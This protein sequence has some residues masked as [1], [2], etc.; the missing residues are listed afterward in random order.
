MVNPQ[1]QPT[2]R[3]RLSSPSREHAPRLQPVSKPFPR[4]PAPVASL[5]GR[6]EASQAI[7]QLVVRPEIRLVTMTGAG[8]I[9]KTCLAL[10]CA[11][12]VLPLF[13]D[14]ACFVPLASVS[15]PDFVLPELIHTLGINKH[16]HLSSLDSLTVF[17]REKHLLLVLDN[18]EH[19]TDAAPLLLD[20][21][22]ACANLTLLVTSRTVLHL[23]GEHVFPVP[24]LVLPD[25]AAANAHTLMTNP[26]VALFVARAQARQPDF[27]V[28]DHNAS[29]LISLCRRLD[30]LPLALELAAARVN[31]LSPQQLLSRLAHRLDLLSQPGH[32]VPKRH[33]TMRATIQWSYD[34]LTAREQEL[35]C[36]LSVFAED[37]SFSI[38]EAWYAQ[39]GANPAWLLEGLSS[40]LDKNLLFQRS[41]GEAEPLFSQLETI[42]AFGQ[43]QLEALGQRENVRAAHAACYAALIPPPSPAQLG[44]AEGTW[45]AFLKQTYPNLLVALHFFKEQQELAQALHLA[46]GM[47]GIWSVNGY[48]SEGIEELEHLLALCH[49]QKECVPS[50]L[51]SVAATLAGRIAWYNTVLVLTRRWYQAALLPDQSVENNPFLILAI[52]GLALIESEQ[53]NYAEYDALYHTW[54]PRLRAGKNPELLARLLSVSPLIWLRRGLLEQAEADARECLALLAVQHEPSWASAVVLHASG[55]IAFVREEWATA[56]ALGQE[57]V[58]MFRQLGM[59]SF[60]LEALCTFAS[61]TAA[62]GNAERAHS[63][64]EEAL[65][66]S[67][68][69]DDPREKSRACCGLGY[70]ALQRAD[71]V[72][73]RRWFEDSLTILLPVK[74]LATR[75][76]HLL[77][78][79]LEGLACITSAQQHFPQTVWLLGAAESVRHWDQYDDPLGKARLW[80]ERACSAARDA[81][82]ESV[83]FAAFAQGQKLTPAQAFVLQKTEKKIPQQLSLPVPST[84]NQRGKKPD[85]PGLPYGQHLTRREMDVLRLLGQGLSNAQIAERLVLSVVTVNSYLRS[86]YS[87]LGVSSRTAAIRFALD[88]HL[89]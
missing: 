22:L 54:L 47:G 58:A 25:R 1:K 36:R 72:E 27:Q 69:I 59:P 56:Y 10:A 55:W 44:L 8:G 9:G 62:L 48:T 82:G 78:G 12:Q 18:F 21:L 63:L 39:L 52:A 29:A 24:P 20:I 17:L 32:A 4:L 76:T 14:G 75:F 45:L 16:S 19:L 57:S 23:P 80:C 35:F 60:A 68:E 38:L 85:Q 33:Q 49:Q 84:Q 70:L 40:L 11:R 50:F 26:C 15:N 2:D 5:I 88:H 30:G 87:K 89:I 67:Q 41:S 6:E 61:E 73:A 37:Y 46:I 65:A 74:Q 31:L 3:E 13:P 51:L 43:E 81:L 79:S 7:C 71:L 53:G 28:T 77:A 83:F 42:R 64:F 34:L 66:L 86:V